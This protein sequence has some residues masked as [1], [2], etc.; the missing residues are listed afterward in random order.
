V[1]IKQCVFEGEEQEMMQKYIAREISILKCE[2][3]PRST[4]SFSFF[5]FI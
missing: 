4:F 2:L 1:A 3:R 5:T